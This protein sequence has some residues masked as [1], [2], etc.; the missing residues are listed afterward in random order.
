MGI[1][2]PVIFLAEKGMLH[3]F[4]FA[5]FSEGSEQRSERLKERRG[6]PCHLEFGPKTQSSVLTTLSDA[7]LKLQITLCEKAPPLQLLG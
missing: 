2:S 7:Q 4:N 1:M 3:C 5:N 6:G